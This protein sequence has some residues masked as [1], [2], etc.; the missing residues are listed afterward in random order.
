MKRQRVFK[1]ISIK[2]HL[3]GQPRSPNLCRGLFASKGRM[4]KHG[5][6]LEL[7]CFVKYLH[8]YS[9]NCFWNWG[10]EKAICS[11]IVHRK[12]CHKGN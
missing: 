2:I 6:I 12:L 3:S 5:F 11:H 9:M 1:K 7:T 10:R 4:Q 8:K